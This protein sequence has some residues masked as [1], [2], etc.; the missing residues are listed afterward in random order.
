MTVDDG[1]PD[2]SSNN[3]GRRKNN[4]PGDWYRTGRLYGLRQSKNQHLPLWLRL[5]YYCY[6]GMGSDNHMR[7]ERGEL[8]R[9]F[10]TDTRRIR[11]ARKTAI[12]KEHLDVASNHLCLVAPFDLGFMNAPVGGSKCKCH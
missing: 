7:V 3:R 6:A 9:V 4:V 11:E 2:P 10:N 8:E 1:N 5:S 12:E